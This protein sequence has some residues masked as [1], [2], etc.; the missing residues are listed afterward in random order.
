MVFGI[1]TDIIEIDRLAAAFKRNRNF[2]VRIFRPCELE[3]CLKHQNCFPHLAARFAAKEAVA[4][5]LGRSFSWQDVEVSNDGRG[6]PMVKLYGKAA[7][8]AAGRHVMLSISHCHSY[9]TAVAVLVEE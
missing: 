2:G 3:Y 4:K 1:G 7:E 5:A 6:K 8:V 9:A